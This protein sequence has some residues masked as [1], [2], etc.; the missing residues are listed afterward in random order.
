VADVA[1]RPVHGDQPQVRAEV[2][3][4]GDGVD[5]DVEPVLAAAICLLIRGD[6][7]VVGAEPAGV[8]GLVRRPA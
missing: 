2:V 3:R 4:D 8:V 5:D 7:E 1:E 6:D